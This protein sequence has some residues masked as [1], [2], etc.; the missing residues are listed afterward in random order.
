MIAASIK[1]NQMDTVLQ[2]LQEVPG[3]Y[4]LIEIWI[5]EI[6]NVDVGKLLEKA[7]K[8]LLI[9]ITDTSNQELIDEVL[10]H[11]PAYLDID[12][13]SFDPDLI[14]KKKNTKLILSFH[15]FTGTHLY[16]GALE[17]AKKMKALGA[18][19]GKIIMTAEKVEDNLI[20]LRLLAESETMGLPLVSFC[21]SEK[22]RLS[23][24]I[25]ASFGN[26]INFVP[27]N[28]EWKTAEGQIELSEW[29]DLRK[30]LKF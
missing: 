28:A 7:N 23:R 17:I 8:P 1:E 21:M 25:S 29:E 9:K 27:P 16:S 11:D 19:I 13:D 2:K 26:M 24:I 6:Q 3:N 14:S 20:P 12:L 4:D 15:N 5:N 30:K 18:D 22:G 10:A